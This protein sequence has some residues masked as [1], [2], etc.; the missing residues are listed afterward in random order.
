MTRQCTSRKENGQRCRAASLLEG[1]FSL[2][3]DPDHAAEV[4]ES[5]RLGC[6]WRRREAA[7]V[8]VYD[9]VDWGRCQASEINHG[10]G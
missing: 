7:V 1:E 9:L 4:A 3:H 10:L 8:G 6:L 5:R 2:M